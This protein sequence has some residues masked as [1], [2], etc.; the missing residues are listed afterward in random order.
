[1]Y[2]DVKSEEI[3]YKSLRETVLGG[4]YGITTDNLLTG[5]ELMNKMKLMRSFDMTVKNKSFLEVMCPS[6]I[7][8]DYAKA[9]TK[10]RM[11]YQNA[12]HDPM[13]TWTINL[14]NQSKLFTL[15]CFEEFTRTPKELLLMK[16]F[17]MSC[18]INLIV[19]TYDLV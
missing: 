3:K 17:A 16:C 4:L 1:M 12:K 9:T 7:R 14:K 19:A 10:M 8:S 13:K 11:I 2:D 15:K 6:D 18:G 5:M